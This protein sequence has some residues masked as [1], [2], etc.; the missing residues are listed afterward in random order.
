[1]IDELYRLALDTLRSHC[2]A[3]RMPYSEDDGDLLLAGHRLG[4]SIAFEGFSRQG[5]KLIA[6]LDVQIHLN[7]DTGDRFRVGTL[8]IGDD[9]LSAMRAAIEEW[10]LLAASAVLAA[11]GAEVDTRRAAPVRNLAGWQL[12]PGRAGIRGTLPAGL[13]PGGVFYR[14][15]LDVLRKHIA[16]WPRAEGSQLHLRS[17]FVM[18]TSAEGQNELQAAVDGFLQPALVADLTALPWPAAGEAYLFKQLLVL[19]TGQP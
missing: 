16:A 5:D 9:R 18:A 17:I 4:L 10:H 1:M 15:L 13:N 7:G 2:D 19:R 11:L 12:F 8:G 6:P 14:Q 3:A